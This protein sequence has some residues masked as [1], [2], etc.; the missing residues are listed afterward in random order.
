MVYQLYHK[1]SI[2]VLPNRLRLLHG[3]KRKGCES[4]AFGFRKCVRV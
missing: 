2:Y 3:V 1:S 4:R